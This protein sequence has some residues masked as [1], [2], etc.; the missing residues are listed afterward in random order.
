MKIVLPMELRARIEREARKAFPRECCG[1]IEGIREGDVAHGIA[2]H[3]A[4]NV[5]KGLD[6]FEIAPA[7]HFAALKAARE[8]GRILIGCYH[9]HPNGNAL[10]SPA[11]KAG[12]G[13]EGFFWLIAGLSG[14]GA[15]VALAAFVYCAAGFLEA[16]VSEV[17]GADL[18]TSSGKARS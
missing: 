9:S 3:S 15:A 2:L 17:L 16:E 12:A 18:V 10:P 4:R 6:R 8:N 11:D 7:D 13:E 1:L 14:P 5:A